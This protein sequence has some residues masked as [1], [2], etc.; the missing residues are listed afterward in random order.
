MKYYGYGFSFTIYPPYRHSFLRL[1]QNNQRNY[2]LLLMN[3]QQKAHILLRISQKDHKHF[4]NSKEKYKYS[5]VKMMILEVD[6]K[7]QPKRFVT[8]LYDK[9]RDCEIE[10]DFMPGDYMI[11][12]EI[13]WE[14]SLNREAVF[15]K[16]ILRLGINLNRHL[17]RNIRD[18]I[19][20][21]LS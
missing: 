8:G 3:I 20:D 13:D 9:G 11:Y 7:L 10:D 14:Q 1:K 4:L 12:I 18:F 2:S 16:L 5:L 15:S 21:Q 6:G 17:W 19:R